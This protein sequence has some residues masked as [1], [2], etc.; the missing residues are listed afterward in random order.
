MKPKIS[1]VLILAALSMLVASCSHGNSGSSSSTS[2]NTPSL[3]ESAPAQQKKF[4]AIIV[5]HEPSEKEADSFMGGQMSAAE[6]QQFASK[7]STSRASRK[8]ELS[9]LLG[10]GEVNGWIGEVHSVRDITSN[11]VGVMLDVGCD[12]KLEAVALDSEL[13]AQTVIPKSSPLYAVAKGLKEGDRVSFSGRFIRKASLPDG[14]QE[15]SA[16]PFPS[17]DEPRFNFEITKLTAPQ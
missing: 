8:S 12:A 14:Y 16:G 17:L 9:A 7:M 4:C 13:T 3:L 6:K 10:S 15:L 2:S 11:D 5:R 1:T